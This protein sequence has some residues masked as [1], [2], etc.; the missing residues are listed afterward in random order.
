MPSP[1]D[2]PSPAHAVAHRRV[3]RRHRLAV[4][5]DLLSQATGDAGLRIRELDALGPNPTPAA[6]DSPLAIRQRHRMR[7][8]RQIVPGAIPRAPHATRP[9][10]TATARIAAR[11]APFDSNLDA[12]RRIPIL[13]VHSLDAETGQPQDPRTI[14]PQSHASSLVASTTERTTPGG[15][16]PIGIALRRLNYGL[17]GLPR[18][19]RPTPGGVK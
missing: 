8:P 12:T 9:S 18:R 3:T 15:S 14:A 7:R 19:S 1:H 17:R 4:D 16:V 11:A 10:A 5:T 2:G 6:L 13:S